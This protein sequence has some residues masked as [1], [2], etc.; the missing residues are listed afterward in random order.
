[1][2]PQSDLGKGAVMGSSLMSV[3]PSAYLSAWPSVC[4]HGTT[5]LPPYGCSWKYCTG[6]FYENASRL[7]SFV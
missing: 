3:G 2:P 1:M 6:N 5:R 4:S 7:S